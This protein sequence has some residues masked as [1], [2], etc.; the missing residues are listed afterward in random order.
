MIGT[1]ARG[2]RVRGPDRPE[3]DTLDDLTSGLEP[4][5]RV[6]TVTLGDIPEF[7]LEGYGAPRRLTQEERR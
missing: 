3:S 5:G 2:E 7:R 6:G 1:G 4:V